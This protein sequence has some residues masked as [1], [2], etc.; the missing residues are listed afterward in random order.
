MTLCHT[1][2]ISAILIFNVQSTKPLPLIAIPPLALYTGAYILKSTGCKMLAS[3]CTAQVVA[4]G[5]TAVGMV[6][7]NYATMRG[8]EAIDKK[9]RPE[10]YQAQPQ[11][12][13]MA[14]VGLSNKQLK[15]LL[16]TMTP[17]ERKELLTKASSC[18][19]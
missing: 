5:P 6:A 8:V 19:S 3:W 17:E 11:Q 7:G 9:L 10:K 14:I 1:A 15:E 4:Y 2:L 18:Q 12:T 16:E 13:K